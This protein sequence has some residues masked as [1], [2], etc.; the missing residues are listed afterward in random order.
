MGMSSFLRS[1]LWKAI[2]LH[3]SKGDYTESLRDAMFFVNELVRE[4]GGLRDK[5]GTSLMDSSFLGNNPAIK[6]TK[7]E[8]QTEKDIQAGVGY[9]LKGLCLSVRNPLSHNKVDFQKDDADAIIVYINYLLNIV[10]TSKGKNKIDDIMDFITDINFVN[11]KE[12]AIELMKEIPKH[13]RYDL[14]IQMFRNREKFA[15]NKINCLVDSLLNTLSEKEHRDFVDV[16]NTE[17]LRCNDD[18]KLKSFLHIYG[19]YLYDEIEV[20]CKLRIESLV[21]ESIIKGLYGIFGDYLYEDPECNG[22]GELA[23]YVSGNVFEKLQTKEELLKI[24]QSKLR[25]GRDEIEYVLR[26]F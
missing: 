24:L 10:D 17:L 20:L 22:Y 9:A 13:K 12:Y 23:T 21:K 2:E 16:A 15:D 7:C 6:V 18:K 1:D 14:M 4:K 11:S 3:Y 5:D 25:K 8:T 26:Y 19:R